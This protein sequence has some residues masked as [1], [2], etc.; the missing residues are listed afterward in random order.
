MQHKFNTQRELNVRNKR[1]FIHKGVDI[2][3]PVGFIVR[4]VSDWMVTITLL[5]LNFDPPVEDFNLFF[6]T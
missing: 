2:F 1:I 5:A 3:G 4:A 6:R